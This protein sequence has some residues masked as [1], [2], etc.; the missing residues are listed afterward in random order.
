MIKIIQDNRANFVYRVKCS[1]CQSIYE[2]DI[3]DWQWNAIHSTIGTYC[4]CCNRFQAQTK[5]KLKKR[6]KK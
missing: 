3:E 2:Y 6:K 5:A 4:P 1:Y